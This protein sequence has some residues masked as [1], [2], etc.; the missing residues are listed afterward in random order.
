MIP[1]T[2]VQTE[3]VTFDHWLA[4]IDDVINR[5]IRHCHP[6]EWKE[7]L[8]TFNWLSALVETHK[9]VT[10]ADLDTPFT[11]RWDAYKADGRVE[12]KFGDVGVIVHFHLRAGGETASV[13][14][15][16]FLEA[17]RVDAKT[18]YPNIEWS[19]LKRESENIANHRVLLYDFESAEGSSLNLQ[20]H[21]FC[22]HL[23][24]EPYGTVHASVVITQH[25]LALQSRRRDISRL[26]VP[27]GYQLCTRYL[28]GFDLDFKLDPAEIYDNIPGGP[29]F[30]LVANVDTTGSSSERSNAP[31]PSGYGPI[32]ETHQVH[33]PQVHEATYQCG[34]WEQRPMKNKEEEMEGPV[35]QA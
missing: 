18:G 27:L 2:A 33:R 3:S 24:T 1:Q 20:G 5:K 16:G 35:A 26:G 12:T 13:T 25:L 21:G 4:D 6:R 29:Q 11:V 8:I 9:Q 23:E 17:K 22:R 30:L 7:D 19:Q 28:R 15:I 34:S 14:G 10:I 31:L 32:A